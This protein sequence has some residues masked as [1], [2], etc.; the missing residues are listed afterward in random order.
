M[1][2]IEK[3]KLNKLIISV[4]KSINDLKSQEQTEFN[5]GKMQVYSEV[6]LILGMSDDR[7]KKITEFK[8][9]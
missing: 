2:N 4:A 1:N 8:S 5:K 3:D 9:E 6:L 7:I